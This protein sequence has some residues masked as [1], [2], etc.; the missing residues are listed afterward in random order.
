MCDRFGTIQPNHVVMVAGKRIADGSK[1]AAKRVPGKT[2]VS[3]PRR[4]NAKRAIGAA[5]PLEI[6]LEG[7]PS[8]RP[9]PAAKP[10]FSPETALRA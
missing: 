3:P 2:R 6:L 1:G 4:M 5:A 7:W 8:C 9:T 10:P